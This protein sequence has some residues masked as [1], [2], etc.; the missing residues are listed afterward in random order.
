MSNL[1]LD[2]EIVQVKFR[3]AFYNYIRPH[4]APD[5]RTPASVAGI[6]VIGEDKWRTITE[7]ARGNK[8]KHD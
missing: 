6:E 1:Q 4:L 8:V 2:Y 7:N 3:D 5:G